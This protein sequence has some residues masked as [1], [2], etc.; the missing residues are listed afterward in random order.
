MVHMVREGD[1][2]Y[3][4]AVERIDLEAPLYHP[5]TQSDAY[6]ME[7]NP[8]ETAPEPESVNVDDFD[9]EA[10]TAYKLHPFDGMLTS[11][12]L[13]KGVVA[14]NVYDDNLQILPDIPPQP[15]H[16]K[17]HIKSMLPKEAFKAGDWQYSIIEK[18]N[19]K[20]IWLNTGKN[21]LL[22]MIQ[23]NQKRTKS[24]PFYQLADANDI[25]LTD[26]FRVSQGETNANA[27][28][29][30]IGQEY[31]KAFL[32]QNGVWVDTYPLQISQKYPEAEI[33]YSKISLALDSSGVGDPESIIICGDL[34]NVM[35]LSYLST[36]F[37]ESRV[38][39][40]RYHD[41]V[42]SSEL[43]AQYDM[44]YLVQF[45]LP[46][47]LASKALNIDNPLYT[48]SN[49]LP[50]AIIEGQKVFKIAWHGFVILGLLFLLTLFSTV[51]ILQSN[52]EYR[53]VKDL[54]FRLDLEVNQK[55]LAAAEI[56]KIRSDLE[57]HEANIEAM[58]ILLQ[59]KNPWTEVLRILIQDIR[60][61]SGTWL[62][63]LRLDKGRLYMS[64]YTIDR[65]NVLGISELF[66]NT[67]ISKVTHSQ[68]RYRSVW[69]YE[70]SCDLPKVDWFGLIEADLEKLI[71]M[72]E[73]YGESPAT[74]PKPAAKPAAAPVSE[75]KTEEPSAPVAVH[76]A[77]SFLG[78][79][80]EAYMLYPTEALLEETDKSERNDYS[81]FINSTTKGSTWHYR[82]LGIRFIK[83]YPQSN[84]MT[85]VRWHLAHRYYMDKE[86]VYALQ[87]LDPLI[88]NHNEFYPYALALGARIEYAA[89]SGRYREFYNILRSDY[90]THRILMLI[91]EDLAA[92]EGLR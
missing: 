64:G 9:S 59:D 47:A 8:W 10:M 76:V 31:R 46:I 67:L 72:K 18:D 28:L 55:R 1:H 15:R 22:E 34:A 20:Q 77:P 83:N 70:M 91:R 88:R 35:T 53:R 69:Q 75:P 92:I 21:K 42:T 68:I 30:Y 5:A 84:L 4:N 23:D 66:P 73:V 38:E 27:L 52:Q 17:K 36:Q 71:R 12:D 3:L 90:P 85:F 45:A 58:R 74:P 11:Y 6:A 61:R 19:E 56:K 29:V 63:N 48:R 79:I 89:K 43:E 2:V 41:V 86:Y 78:A 49:F 44:D 50:S 57:L 40:L 60:R 82:D 62:T 13:K 16:I 25:A 26:Y 54:S 51:K 39:F 65:N 81:A 32:F 24:L 87:N 37:T 33:V 7:E 80:P 14:L